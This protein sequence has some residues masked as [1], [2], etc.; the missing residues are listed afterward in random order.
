MLSWKHVQEEENLTVSSS[1]YRQMMAQADN[2]PISQ[3]SM[4][5]LLSYSLPDRV[6]L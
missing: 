1:S 5:M 3:D 6:M 2:A 4:S